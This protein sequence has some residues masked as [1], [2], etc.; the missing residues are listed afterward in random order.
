MDVIRK[1]KVRMGVDPLGGAGA[2]YW[3][4]IDERYRLAP[5]VT[6]EIV[7]STFAFMPLDWTARYAWIRRRRM[8]CNGW[9]T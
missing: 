8:P 2:H 9:C 3:A 7:N 6:S 1:A 4:A 5:T